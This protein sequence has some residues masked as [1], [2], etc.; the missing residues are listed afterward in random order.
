MFRRTSS[1][2]VTTSY[3][4][5]V[6]A[7]AV[8]RASVHSTLI[9]VVLPAPFGPRNPNVSPRRTSKSTPP[10]ASIWTYR[11]ARPRTAMIGSPA[12]PGAAGWVGFGRSTR[13]STG[14]PRIASTAYAAARGGGSGAG[15]LD[16][17]GPGGRRA[18]GA[19]RQGHRGR[20]GP[21]ALPDRRPGVRRVEPV[22]A[23]GRAAA[24]GDSPGLRL[25][26]ER[27]LPAA[28]QHVPAHGRP[29]PARPGHAAPPHLR[30]P[31]GRRGR[32]G[33]PPPLN[34]RYLH[35]R[36]QH[37][38]E[39]RDEA[40]SE[41]RGADPGRRR[42]VPVV[43][44]LARR[45]PPAPAGARRHRMGVGEH[46]R[47]GVAGPRSGP[48]PRHQGHSG[49]V[50]CGPR[51][52][53]GHRGPSPRAGPPR[54]ARGSGQGRG[55]GPGAEGRGRRHPSAAPAPARSPVTVGRALVAPHATD[56]AS[57][58]LTVAARKRWAAS[59]V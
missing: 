7:P 48:H 50:R 25:D 30:G 32:R 47:R 53:Q 12:G 44:P 52:R 3:P 13:F 17:G 37:E 57:V 41:L 55:V 5:T 16:R 23:P 26:R 43:W 27:D 18:G 21:P 58:F 31:R 35:A 1:R 4:A 54:G 29:G 10:T 9:V 39:R 40:L 2:W 24:Q 45:R 36:D 33:P 20:C 34:W 15:W 19:R 51:R 22:H 49:R 42:E 28:R 56:P 6:A 8:G 38:G 11:L 46:L 59:K 14:V